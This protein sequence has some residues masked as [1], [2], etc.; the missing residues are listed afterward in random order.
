MTRRHFFGR[1][2]DG[3]YGVALTHLLTGDLFGGSGLAG[4]SRPPAPGRGGIHDVAPRKPHFEAK[5]KSVILL[6]M[7]GGPSP[8]DLLDPKPMLNKHHGEPYFD[9]V[10]VDVPS[11]QQ[12]GG[13]LRSPF[14]FAQHGQSG[15]WVSEAMPHIARRVGRH[16]GHPVDA[17]HQ[18][19]PSGRALQVSGGAHVAGHPHPGG[20]G[21][22][23]DW[24]PRTGTCR[25]SWCWTTPRA[26]PSTASPTGSRG[27][28]LPSTRGRAC[29]RWEIR[30]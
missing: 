24:G 25:P 21:W 6:F 20:P 7:N 13:L 2:S 5:A 29:A 10:A 28:C 14:K 22:S 27:F 11:P 16:R 18:S 12:A 26:C 30:C 4:E 3:I 1:V 23:T 15:T 17:H 8:M 9:Q 19:G